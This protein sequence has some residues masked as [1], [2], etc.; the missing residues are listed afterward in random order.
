MDVQGSRQEIPALQLPRGAVRV[1]MWRFT[2]GF[3]VFFNCFE[4][5]V[6]LYLSAA[7]VFR[8]LT[9][10]TSCA[11]RCFLSRQFFCYDLKSV[12]DVQM[13]TFTGA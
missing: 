12:H 10:V 1:A 13:K 4:R 3:G 9:H 11:R 7:S 6:A 2:S 5:T 8:H